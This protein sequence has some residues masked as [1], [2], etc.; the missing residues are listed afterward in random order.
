MAGRGGAGMMGEE[1]SGT[2]VCLRLLVEQSIQRV[3][4]RGEA[5]WAAAEPT[6]AEVTVGRVHRGSRTRHCPTARVCTAVYAWGTGGGMVC[7][8]PRTG[9]LCEWDGCECVGTV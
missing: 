4:A 1:R 5:D 7:V 9:Q 2:H 6:A 3:S 8:C